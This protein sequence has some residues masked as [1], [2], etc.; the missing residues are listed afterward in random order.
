MFHRGVEVLDQELA[1]GQR[2]LDAGSHSP[3][4][5]SPLTCGTANSTST[6]VW[7]TENGRVKYEGN[8]SITMVRIGSGLAWGALRKRQRGS[9]E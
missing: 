9:E 3:V 7:K 1:L 5:N 6:S 8:V 2:I 4:M